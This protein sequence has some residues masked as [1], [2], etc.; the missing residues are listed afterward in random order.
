M[1]LNPASGAGREDPHERREREKRV[2]EQERR[3]EL[4]G[5]SGWRRPVKEHKDGCAHLVGREAWRVG[6]ASS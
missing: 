6:S 3:D 2:W 5:E 1:T 4:N